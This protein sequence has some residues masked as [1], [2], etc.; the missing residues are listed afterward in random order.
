M[1]TTASHTPGPWTLSPWTASSDIAIH[2]YNDGQRQWIGDVVG[3]T[4]SEHATDANRDANARLIAAAPDML[5]ALKGLM[6]MW[7]SGIDEP[8]VKA[9][10][11]AIAKATGTEQRREG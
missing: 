1:P 9:A 6:P 5:E 2:G 4:D 7:Q 10:R 3:D 11:D 8:W